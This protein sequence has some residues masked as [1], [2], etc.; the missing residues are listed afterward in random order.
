MPTGADFGDQLAALHSVSVEIA[1]L[2]DLAEVHERALEHGLRLTHSAFAF[3]GLLVESPRVME[4]AAVKG[5]DPGSQ[6]FYDQFH[7]MAVRSSVVGVVIREERPY[8][9]N[10]VERDPHAVGQPPGHPQIHRFLG[11]PLQVGERLI[12]MMGV[13]NKEAGYGS[14]DQ[15]LLSTLANQVAVAIDN[16]RLYGQQRDMISALEQLH[17]RLGDDQRAQ[18]L[19]SE[20]DRIARGLHDR[21]DQEIFTIGL[22]LNALLE[23][24][25]LPAPLAERLR[26][27]RRVAVQASDEVRQAIFD[28]A[29]SHGGERDLASALRSLLREVERNSGL[30]AHL[31]VS[32]SPE[33]AVEQVRDVAVTV[34]REALTN[35]VKHARARMVLVS[36]RHGQSHVDLVIQDDGVGAPEPVLRDYPGS[37]LHFGLRNMRETVVGLGGSFEV[38]NGEEG[39]LTVRAS[40]PLG[41]RNG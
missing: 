13:A 23:D 33:A 26:E 1:A 21:V 30:Q 8:I 5:F 29:A 39:G 7:R 27:I 15:I 10:D 32:G 28:L 36:I 11:V 31:V 6:G 19:A 4:V 22:R 18:L 9:S 35:V 2:H 34:V 37:Y 25:P 24:E 16:A 3:T 38:S 41:A 20:R 17:T 14:D 12:G 40:L